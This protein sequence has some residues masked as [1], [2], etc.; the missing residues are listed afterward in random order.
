MKKLI[1]KI[2]PL[3]VLVFSIIP[4]IS[5]SQFQVKKIV[6][7]KDFIANYYANE[8]YVVIT[9]FSKYVPFIYTDINKNNL[10][11]PYV[12]KLFSVSQGGI[13]A[14]NVLEDGANTTCNQATN[15]ILLV[16]NNEYQFIIPKNEL[17]YIPKEPIFLTFAVWDEEKKIHYKITNSDKSYILQ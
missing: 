6:F 13:C 1:K 3:L 5:F 9:I 7:E 15:A 10:I 2:T 12:E 17:T 11:D 4:F 14:S 8:D 16:K